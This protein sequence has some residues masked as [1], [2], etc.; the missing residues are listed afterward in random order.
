[1]R[2]RRKNKKNIRKLNMIYHCKKMYITI[3]LQRVYKGDCN[4]DV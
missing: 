3:L 4:K 1:M 2:K